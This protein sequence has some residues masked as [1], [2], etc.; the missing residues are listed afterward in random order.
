MI[1][2]IAVTAPLDGGGAERNRE[3]TL[4]I[5]DKC[6]HAPESREREREESEER[7][8]WTPEQVEGEAIRYVLIAPFRAP[9]F[10][11]QSC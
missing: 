1:R 11:L 4:H 2:L 7:S 8:K 3:G 5:E 6:T 9:L 10:A